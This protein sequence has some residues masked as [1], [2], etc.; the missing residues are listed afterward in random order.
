M[1]TSSSLL[2]EDEIISLKSRVKAE[3][4]R[5]RYTGSVSSYGS[6]SYDFNITPNTGVEALTEHH[7]KISVPLNAINN[8][9]NLTI[10]SQGTIIT[11]S[12][13]T[14]MQNIVSNL[15]GKSLYA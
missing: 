2:T 9:N 13:I 14:N 1:P 4:L 11:A 8:S 6:S 3:C 12:D 5:R 7:D 15:E 10:N